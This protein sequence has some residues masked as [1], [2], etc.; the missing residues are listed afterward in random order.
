[1]IW[2]KAIQKGWLSQTQYEEALQISTQQNQTLLFVIQEKGLLT[3]EQLDFIRSEL[4]SSKTVAIASLFLENTPSM[5]S[6]EIFTS[7]TKTDIPTIFEASTLAFSL[8]DEKKLFAAIPTPNLGIEEDKVTRIQSVMNS[9]VRTQMGILQDLANSSQKGSTSTGEFKIKKLGDYWLKEELGRGGMG[10]V[11]RAYHENLNQF[12]AIKILLSGELASSD[13]IERF[14]QEAKTNAKLR[15]SSIIQVL[16]SGEEENYH[17]MVME[18]IS[19]GTLAKKIIQSPPTIRESLIII[20]NT[21][22]ALKYAHEQGVIHRDIKLEN[23]FAL[24]NGEIKLA[25]FGLAKDIFLDNQSQKITQS[26]MI[27]GTPA[28]MSPEQ[29]LG[30]GSQIDGQSDLYGVGVCLYELLT[31]Q[32][33]FMGNSLHDVLI[34]IL[35]EEPLPPSKRIPNIHKDI[36]IIVLRAIEKDKTKRYASAQEFMTDI[37]LFLKGYP[38]RSRPNTPQEIFLKWIKRHRMLSFFLGFLF[39]IFLGSGIDRIRNRKFNEKLMGQHIDLLIAQIQQALRH[40]LVPAESSLNQLK[41]LIENNLAPHQELSKFMIFLKGV[42]LQSSDFTNVGYGDNSG[43]F[44]MVSRTEEKIRYKNVVFNN[45]K[46]S[47]FWRENPEEEPQ[48]VTSAENFDCRKRPWFQL[49]EKNLGIS[50]TDPYMMFSSQKPGITCLTPIFQGNQFQGVIFID[51]N[52]NNISRFV[53]EFD[54]ILEGIITNNTGDIFAYSRES[55]PVEQKDSKLVLPNIQQV[56]NEF[57]PKAEIVRFLKVLNQETTLATASQMVFFYKNDHR[58]LLGMFPFKVKNQEWCFWYVIGE[59]KFL[60]PPPID[61][62]TLLLASFV[63]II[64]V[65]TFLIRYYRGQE[66]VDS[67]GLA[68]LS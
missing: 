8:E 25:D 22:E 4:E 7:E 27:L 35:K 9:Q 48:E 64:L 40:Y 61:D 55:W 12:Y 49:G 62:L 24:D 39:L 50:W 37:D 41:Y 60:D 36:D 43:S 53:S 13:A 20:Q 5:A 28:Y 32:C 1:M 65:L 67:S 58:Y 52:T 30:R 17:Y 19:G 11:Y 33:P 44:V 45:E 6:E 57:L 29:V 38:I 47:S 56:Q 21:L 16:N 51:I 18:L 15:H 3:P 63:V 59:S 2:L 66:I 23:I 10:V 42:L 31:K 54:L 14:H 68:Q 34:K 46:F 26:G